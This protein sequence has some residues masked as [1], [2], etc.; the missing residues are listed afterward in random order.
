M[1]SRSR[2]LGSPPLG[3]GTVRRHADDASLPHSGS[4]YLLGKCGRLINRACLHLFMDVSFAMKAS[5]SLHVSG[6]G[7]VG[8]NWGQNHEGHV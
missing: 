5:R 6:A 7:Q 8:Q 2:S 4:W 1:P 3:G